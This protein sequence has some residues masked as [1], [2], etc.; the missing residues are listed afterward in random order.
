MSMT[1][2]AFTLIELL[3]VI[4]IIA[5][6][7]AILF[8]VF[9]A[10]KESAKATAVLS[11]M[12]QIGTGILM[13]GA[14]YDDMCMS[15]V[16]RT[17]LVANPRRQDLLTWPQALQPYIKNGKPETVPP[18]TGTD[19]P[20]QGMFNNQL[21]SFTKYDIAFQAPDC[22]A[23]SM[24]ALGWLPLRWAHAYYGIGIGVTGG[25]CVSAD[26]FYFFAGSNLGSTNPVNHIRMSLT[27]P[28]RIPEMAI[29]GDGY[30]GTAGPNANPIMFTSIGCESADMYK[31]G[32]NFAFLDSHSRFVKGNSQRYHNVDGAGCVYMKYFTIDR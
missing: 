15:W 3:V 18:V 21:W 13:Y 28:E 20:P 1:R 12:K 17:G 32:G 25:T 9:A 22:N 7:A 6:L 10:A 8:P 19:G 2:R 5:I 14:D 11:Y 24:A 29:V 23:I 26:P 16:T 4:A 31:G 27:Q 30:T